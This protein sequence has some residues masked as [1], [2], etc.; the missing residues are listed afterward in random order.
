MQN[1]R[2]GGGV[3]VLWWAAWMMLVTGAFLIQA[4][5]HVVI[6]ERGYEN[7]SRDVGFNFRSIRTRTRSKQTGNDF[8]LAEFLYHPGDKTVK[9][10][11]MSRMPE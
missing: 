4:Q 7:A 10:L 9:L 1:W 8:M 11:M 5:I 2:E 3:G 6:S